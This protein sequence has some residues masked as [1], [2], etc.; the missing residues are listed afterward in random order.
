M[1]FQYFLPKVL[2]DVYNTQWD[3]LTSVENSEAIQKWQLT[4]GVLQV[5]VRQLIDLPVFLP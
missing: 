2:Q 4:F 5:N 1:Q 3:N